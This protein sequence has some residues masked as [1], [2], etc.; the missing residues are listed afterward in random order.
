MMQST[1]AAED[2]SHGRFLFCTTMIYLFMH[3]IVNTVYTIQHKNIPKHFPLWQWLRK[4]TGSN[5]YSSIVETKQCARD[6]WLSVAGMTCFPTHHYNS[7]SET[8][9]Q[10][11]VWLANL[12]SSF[13]LPTEK[14]DP[15]RLNYISHYHSVIVGLNYHFQNLQIIFICFSSLQTQTASSIIINYL[16]S[17]GSW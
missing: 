6:Q 3:V 8:L 11:T 4:W 16:I 17:E 5:R 12:I 7:G 10:V 14:M 13:E 9:H 2:L 15:S 1:V